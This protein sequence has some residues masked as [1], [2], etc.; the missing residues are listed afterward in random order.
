MHRFHTLPFLLALLKEDKHALPRALRLA[1]QAE[2][3]V[4]G[5]VLEKEREPGI[6]K[7]LGTHLDGLGLR[8]FYDGRDRT[9][10]TREKEE[11]GPSVFRSEHEASTVMSDTGARVRERGRDDGRGR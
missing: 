8:G 4:L 10:E 9:E 11:P 2:E 7:R 6:E 5:R 1:G 3:Y